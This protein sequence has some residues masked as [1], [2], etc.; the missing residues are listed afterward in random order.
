M[1][2]LYL[3]MDGVVADWD[4]AATELIGR[5]RK[6]QD[7][8]W[9][10]EDW[11]AIKQSKHFYRHLPLMDQAELLVETA[12]SFRAR[13]WSL[14]FL[15]AIPKHN[16]QPW[17]FNDKML[18]ARDHFPDIPVHFGPYAEDKQLHARQGDIL[19]DDQPSNCEQWQARGGVSILVRNANTAP[20]IARLSQLLASERT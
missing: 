5:P 19:V 16:D 6:S 3:D 17:A 20:A 9:G 8:R 11:Q 2:T 10:A 18:W 15:T 1:N 12:R 13:G 7:G 4:R 14:L